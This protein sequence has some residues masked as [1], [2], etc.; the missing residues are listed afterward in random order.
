MWNVARK[1]M[2]NTK[3]KQSKMC[4]HTLDA[5]SKL[6][7]SKKNARNSS[8]LH[9]FR[10]I[11]K[12]Y[13][14]NFTG[15]IS[16]KKKYDSLLWIDWNMWESVRAKVIIRE[17]ISHHFNSETLQFRAQNFACIP[18]SCATAGTTNF[19]HFYEYTTKCTYR[20]RRKQVASQFVCVCHICVFYFV[21]KFLIQI[22]WFPTCYETVRQF[23]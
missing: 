8:S 11:R 9:E 17:I 6:K 4:G 18:H 14:S 10:E 5:V 19:I 3:L 2:T 7:Q 20:L 12:C 22:N 23:K 15:S 1:K 16:N 13:L 21:R